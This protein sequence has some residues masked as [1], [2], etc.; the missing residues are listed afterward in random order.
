MEFCCSVGVGGVGGCCSNPIHSSGHPSL[1]SS[2]PIPSTPQGKHAFLPSFLTTNPL[3]NLIP[4][5]PQG[6]RAF[7]TIPVKYTARKIRDHVHRKQQHHQ[8]HHHHHHQQGQHQP[9]A[10]VVPVPSPAEGEGSPLHAP[11][12]SAAAGGVRPLDDEE[13][14]MLKASVGWGRE[15]DRA[16]CRDEGVSA[17]HRHRHTSIN[18]Q[19]L[20]TPPPTPLIPGA[21]VDAGGHQ[22]PTTPQPPHPN[23][24]AVDAYL[25]NT[26]Y[27][28]PT[29]RWMREGIVYRI[30]RGQL[31]DLYWMYATVAPR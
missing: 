3:T 28:N 17:T 5:T 16:V 11:F 24:T 9:Q 4:S 1:I 31:D 12:P 13:A 25:S 19:E 18:T 7:L 23:T 15:G 10:G 20:T 29:Q 14:G 26:P 2:H 27:L 22:L 6:K 30:P 21:A 8:Q